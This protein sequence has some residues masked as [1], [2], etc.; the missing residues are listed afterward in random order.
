ML[1]NVILYLVALVAC[2]ELLTLF[3]LYATVPF[4][5]VACLAGCDGK[6]DA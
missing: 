2:E 5:V 1:L 6:E 4:V 3:A